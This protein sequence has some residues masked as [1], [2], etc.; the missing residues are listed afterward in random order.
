MS[1][2]YTKKVFLIETKSFI[3]FI[4]KKTNFAIGEITAVYIKGQLILKCPFGVFKSSKKNNDFFPGF[5][6]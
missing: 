6:P 2:F 5:L 1:G 4:K 3:D